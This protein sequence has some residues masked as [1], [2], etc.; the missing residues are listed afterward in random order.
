MEVV[1]THWI[2]APTRVVRCLVLSE[3]HLQ[4]FERKIKEKVGPLDYV[5]NVK[6]QMTDWQ[7]FNDDPIF[8][9]YVGLFGERL[10]ASGGLGEAGFCG[11]DIKD[12]W[13]NLLRLDDSVDEHAHV[14]NGVDF[15]SVVY[16][17]ES[18]I[19]VSGTVFENVRGH[20]LTIPASLAH[21]V[22]AAKADRI[23]LAFNWRVKVTENKWDR[24]SKEL[25]NQFSQ[26]RTRWYE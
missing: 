25:V 9:E 20:V 1:E 2:L 14:G 3:A 6:G 11:I 24:E 8:H 22:G 23:T 26:L 12:A 5:T 18:S 16:F 21:S 4:H 17:G 10:R 7:I 19:N 15:A 13:G